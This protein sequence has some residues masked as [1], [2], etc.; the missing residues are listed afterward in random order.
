MDVVGMLKAMFIFLA[1]FCK[2]LGL[3][4]PDLI[5]LIRS[6]SE[7]WRLKNERYKQAVLEAVAAQQR[8]ASEQARK[9]NANLKA[10]RV[11]FDSLWLDTYNQFLQHLNSEKPE[12]ALLMV[13]EQ[14]FAQANEIIFNS[15]STNE[16]KAQRLTD[17]I[18]NG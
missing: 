7:Y 13:R 17:I 10:W 11:I 3:V 18:R 16:V 14:N 2:N 8:A 15:T 12:N 5:S 4:L 6:W 9:E 1:E